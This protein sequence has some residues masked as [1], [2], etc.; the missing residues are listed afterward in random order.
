MACRDDPST[1]THIHTHTHAPV[2]FPLREEQLLGDAWLRDHKLVWQ[3]RQAQR[4]QGRRQGRAPQHERRRRRFAGEVLWHM[5]WR[6]EGRGAPGVLLFSNPTTCACT[7]APQH[8]HL[9]HDRGPH[10]VVQQQVWRALEGRERRHLHHHL[11]LLLGRQRHRHGRDGHLQAGAQGGQCDDWVGGARGV[12]C[13]GLC[14]GASDTGAGAAAACGQWRTGR[15]RD[16]GRMKR[17]TCVHTYTH[18]HAHT[19]THTHTHTHPLNP[20]PPPPPS[21]PFTHTPTPAHLQ[22][23]GR[24]G[25][26]G[27]RLHRCCGVLVAQVQ[28]HLARPVLVPALH[29][30]LRGCSEE[31][32]GGA[33]R[34]AWLSPGA[35]PPLQIMSTLTLE[36]IGSLG[37]L[38]SIGREI[39]KIKITMIHV[40]GGLVVPRRRAAW[41]TPRC[42]HCLCG[43]LCKQRHCPHCLCATTRVSRG[44]DGARQTEGEG[45]E[46]CTGTGEQHPQ[47]G[48]ECCSHTAKGPQAARAC[49]PPSGCQ[50]WP[51][52]FQEF[53]EP[54][55]R[56]HLQV[57]VLVQHA[58]VLHQQVAKPGL[59][60]PDR[61]RRLKMLRSTGWRGRKC[62]CVFV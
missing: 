1:D 51:I 3:H 49:C 14:S 34:A 17:R 45:I 21:T 16:D 39:M 38:E 41:P 26:Y 19:H 7:C 46:A 2:G 42:S 29:P 37:T 56:A 53:K 33:W 15:Q 32:L 60:G 61:L 48:A 62:E 36:D 11:H 47:E 52:E 54:L 12:T 55:P 30:D 9:V 25:P 58:L 24:G 40:E 10:F 20:P 5:A 27:Q 57:L 43:W 23:R 44:R 59:H 31:K 13:S 18:T 8:A 6:Q 50:S 28:D 4:L 22:P 35:G